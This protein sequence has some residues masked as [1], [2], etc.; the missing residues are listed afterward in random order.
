MYAA[1]QG[2]LRTK[3]LQNWSFSWRWWSWTTILCHLLSNEIQQGVMKTRKQTWCTCY[4]DGNA[5]MVYPSQFPKKVDSC[6][7]T[8]WKVLAHQWRFSSF[9]FFEKT[10]CFLGIKSC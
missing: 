4:V 1:V 7:R 2:Q 8:S 9:Q 5:G 6:C 10:R 3:W